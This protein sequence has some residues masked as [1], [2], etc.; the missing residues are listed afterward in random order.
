MSTH[1]NRVEWGVQ[2]SH[3]TT[4][5]TAEDKDLHGIECSYHDNRKENSVKHC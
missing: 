3:S 4:H 1:I 5:F 2:I